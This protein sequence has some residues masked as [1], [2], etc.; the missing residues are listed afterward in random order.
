MDMARI[1]RPGTPNTALGAPAGFVPVPDVVTP[2]FGVGADAVYAAVLAVAE[3][4][5]R[6]FVL[7][8]FDGERQAH[9]VARSAVFGFPDL[10][11]VQVVA[12]GE[13]RAQVI[14]WSRSVYGRSDFGVNRKRVETWLGALEGRLRR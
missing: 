13:G 9:F 1:E 2:G 10:V 8:R 12:E 5:P 14:I 11:A 7:R 4:Q 3:G 6:T